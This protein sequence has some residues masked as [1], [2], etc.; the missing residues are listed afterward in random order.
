MGD[1]PISTEILYILIHYN[2]GENIDNGLNIVMCE[3]GLKSS[4]GQL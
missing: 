2:I 1:G 4:H 3:Q